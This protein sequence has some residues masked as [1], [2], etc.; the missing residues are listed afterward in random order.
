MSVSFGSA[1]YF[2]AIYF[3]YWTQLSASLT[4]LLISG[5]RETLN[6]EENATCSIYQIKL[7]EFVCFV[8][9]L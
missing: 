1:S 4:H 9:F 6:S 7:A 3:T 5:F 2:V 8:C